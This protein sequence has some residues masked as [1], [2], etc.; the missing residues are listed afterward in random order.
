MY[1]WVLLVEIPRRTTASSYR[2]GRCFGTSWA[3]TLDQRLE[4]DADGISFA[5]AET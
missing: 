4:V 3:S 2:A 1:A 5:A